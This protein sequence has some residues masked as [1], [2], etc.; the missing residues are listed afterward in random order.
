MTPKE[1]KKS[2]A[3][4]DLTDEN[5]NVSTNF[6]FKLKIGGVGTQYC[7]NTYLLKETVRHNNFKLVTFFLQIATTLKVGERVL[8]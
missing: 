8:L 5:V 2:P 1:K 4:L 3:L 6:C 7:A